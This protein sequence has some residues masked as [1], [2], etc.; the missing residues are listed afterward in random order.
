[1]SILLV[2]AE[3]RRPRGSEN[4]EGWGAMSDFLLRQ[5]AEVFEDISEQDMTAL[6][7]LD[8]FE[9]DRIESRR[10]YEDFVDLPVAPRP[11]ATG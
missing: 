6:R 9:T 7:A 2:M 4:L 11:L 3:K 10:R 1:M 8:G 5:V